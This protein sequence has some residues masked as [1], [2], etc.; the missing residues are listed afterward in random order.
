MKFRILCLHGYTQ[1]AQRFRDR[2]GPIRRGLKRE[3]EFVYVTAPH[4]AQPLFDSQEEDPEGRA[5]WN[6]KTPD[7][8]QDIQQSIEV[9]G[10]EIEEQGPFDGLLG[11]SQGAGMAAI[12][13]A[14]QPRRFK[15]AMLFAGFYPELSQ[16]DSLVSSRRIAVPSLQ[17][18]GAQDQV[19]SKER[20]Q[21]LAQRAFVDAQ[22]L[23][24]PGGHFIPANAEYRKKYVGFLSSF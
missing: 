23:E 22:L 13:L 20:G 1:N 19:V 14:Q 10:G 12:L 8:W 21:E 2:T 15:F 6:T 18:V 16:F 3:A 11:F 4:T 5:W 17:V 7:V 9:L 24:H